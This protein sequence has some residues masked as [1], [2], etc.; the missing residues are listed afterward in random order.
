M[1]PLARDLEA[2]GV[3]SAWLDGEVVVMN[4][5]G[6][7]DFNALQNAFDGARTESIVYARSSSLLGVP[8]SNCPGRWQ[9]ASIAWLSSDASHKS[10]DALDEPER[11]QCADRVGRNRSSPLRHAIRYRNS[12]HGGEQRQHGGN[13]DELSD[14]DTEIEHE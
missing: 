4:S 12:S 7:P 6:V 9:C 13:E 1:R 8:G 5:D 2:C 14:L 10:C 3:Q 11:G